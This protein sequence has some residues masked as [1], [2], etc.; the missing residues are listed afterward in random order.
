MANKFRPGIPDTFSLNVAPVHDLGDYLDEPPASPRPKKVAVQPVPP[1]PPRAEVPSPSPAVPPASTTPAAPEDAPVPILPAE[2]QPTRPEEVRSVERLPRS[3]PP[4]REITMTAETLRMSD[5][6]L[7]VIRNG[8]G[9]RDTKAS[10]VFHALVLLVHDAIN[11]LEPHSIPRRGQWGT[12]TAR[13]YPIELKIAFLRA[14]LRK[15]GVGEGTAAT[16]LR[17]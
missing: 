11:E 9:Q 7:E 17:P 4:R 12:P 13:A 10:E 6:L 15:H 14:L 3:K 5:E 8:S 16:T 1:T 2:P